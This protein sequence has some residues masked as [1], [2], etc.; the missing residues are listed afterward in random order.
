MSIKAVI[1][2]FAPCLSFSVSRIPSIFMIQGHCLRGT[3]EEEG[4]FLMLSISVC[5]IAF[6]PVA[7]SRRCFVVAF[8][9]CVHAH[10]PG[11]TIDFGEQ[12]D[13][14]QAPCRLLIMKKNT[15]EHIY[16]F[17]LAKQNKTPFPFKQ[18]YSFF[19]HTLH[20]H[21]QVARRPALGPGGWKAKDP[22]RAAAWM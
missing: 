10:L 1:D 22:L 6:L 11:C 4:S 8:C 15:D 3:T 7:V 9:G 17:H 18:P 12:Y 13:K 21:S 19:L 2:F 20:M 16:L 5:S 14:N